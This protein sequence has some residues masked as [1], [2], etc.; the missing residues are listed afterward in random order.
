MPFI[1]I[2]SAFV[3]AIVGALAVGFRSGY[4]FGA[5]LLG[6]TTVAAMTGLASSVLQFVPPR[7]YLI[8]AAVAG[9]LLGLLVGPLLAA[10]ETIGFGDVRGITALIWPVA[11]VAGLVLSRL[12]GMQL[13]TPRR[14]RRPRPGVGRG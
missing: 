11:V 6:A 13:P 9:T 10:A 2:A 5:L 4:P 7:H 1:P 3:I 14:W 8:A 12:S